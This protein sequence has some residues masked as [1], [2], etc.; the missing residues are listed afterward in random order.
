MDAHLNLEYLVG[1]NGKVKYQIDVAFLHYIH[2]A[3]V[4]WIVAMDITT[5]KSL[6]FQSI[7]WILLVP[8]EILVAL[9]HTNYIPQL[10]TGVCMQIPIL[11]VGMFAPN[12]LD[13]HKHEISKDSNVPRRKSNHVRRCDVTDFATI[14]SMVLGRIDVVTSTVGGNLVKDG[15]W[16]WSNGLVLS[17][18][19]HIQSPWWTTLLICAPRMTYYLS[20]QARLHNTCSLQNRRSSHCSTQECNRKEWLS[21]GWATIYASQGMLAH[22]LWLLSW[23]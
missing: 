6:E 20:S 17:H 5:T 10:C 8:R 22:K 1:K 21:R 13:R 7:L 2:V 18:S 23:S 19:M 14:A 12:W 9:N 16:H 11:C 4:L 15:K 3:F